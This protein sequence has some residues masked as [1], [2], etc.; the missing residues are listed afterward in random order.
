M[1]SSTLGPVDGVNWKP[2]RS[3][4]AVSWDGAAVV[5]RHAGGPDA[6]ARELA[7]L[8]RLSDLP[9]PRVLPGT[10]MSAL[11]LA[12]VEG[13]PAVDAIE[14]GH[15]SAVLRAMGEALRALHRVDS[16]RFARDV[17]TGTLTHGDYAPYNVIVSADG[18]VVGAVVDWEMADIADPVMD[19]AWCEAQCLRLFPR[20]RYALP[21]LFAGYGA[22]PSRTEL[23]AALEAR[24]SELSSG[25]R[26]PPILVSPESFHS[27]GFSDSSEGAA[28]IAALSR[29]ASA[30]FRDDCAAPAQIWISSTDHQGIRVLL[31]ATAAAIAARV[32]RAPVARGLVE[33]DGILVFLAGHVPPMG[34]DDVLK[35]L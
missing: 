29:A 24:L 3:G 32:F 19:L 14:A 17:V 1:T 27:I 13:Q 35:L 20:H 30:P 26:R 2:G 28:F 31:N 25:R 15:A 18:D 34:V 5:K 23:D 9:V 21:H 12:F 6:A 10:S 16:R 22:T 4:N 7:M 11:R 33:V 8:A